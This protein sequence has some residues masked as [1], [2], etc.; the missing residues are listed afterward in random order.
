MNI[1][2]ITLYKIE[3]LESSGIYTDLL[4]EF[5]NEGHTVTVICPLE[6]RE[7][8][9][10]QLV[11]EGST[12]ILRVRTLNIQKV[13]LIEKGLGTL[14]LEHQFISS[15]KKHFSDIR[16]NLVLY[17]TP[18]ITF[19]RVVKFIKERDNAFCYLL[20]KDIFPQNAVDLHLMSQ[21]S[22]LYRFFRKKEKTLYAISDKIGCMSPANQKYLLHHNPEIDS[23]KVEINPNTINAKPLIEITPDEKKLIRK[24]Y[25]I[26]ENVRVFCYGGNL[27]LPQGIDS[28]KELLEMYYGD[29]RVHFLIVGSGTEYCGLEKWLIA[30]SST[31]ATLLPFLPHNEYHLLLSACDVGLIFLH[32][33][34]TIPNFPSRLLS[35]LELGLPILSITDSSTDIGDII[36]QAGCGF[37]V[38]ATDKENIKIKM[39]RLLTLEL[40]SMKEA[41]RKLLEQQF[42]VAKSYDLIM[43]AVT[44][45]CAKHPQ[46]N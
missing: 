21:N 6:R 33:D 43:D 37:G 9:S 41:S 38:L 34:F 46:L 16:F 2:F 1:L 24:K 32:R 25:K 4:R 18:P 10:T 11:I 40:D 14:A 39:E 12:R 8:K 28:L 20:L 5:V 36:A 30:R 3:S 42:Q 31:N 22:I 19:S 44:K 7:K 29:E 23:F 17:T 45:S 35:Y 27:G 26:A 15:L 13:N